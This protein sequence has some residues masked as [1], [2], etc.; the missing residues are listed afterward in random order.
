MSGKKKFCLAL[1][2]NAGAI[3][4]ENYERSF[5]N[6]VGLGAAVDYALQWSIEAI[7]QRVISL[8]ASLRHQLAV[9]PNIQV[10][11][12]GMRYIVGEK[13]T[14]SKLPSSPI[15][16]PLPPPAQDRYSLGT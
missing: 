5:A 7:E 14:L 4:Y 11:D 1:Q 9:L 12:F 2:V 10:Q 16:F 15:T 8:A 13:K 3:R 6:W